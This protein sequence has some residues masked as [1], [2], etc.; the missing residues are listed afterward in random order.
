MN[1]T[2]WKAWLSEQLK[3]TWGVI[4]RPSEEGESSV[5][6]RTPACSFKVMAGCGRTGLI[7]KKGRRHEHG[8]GVSWH[9]GLFSTSRVEGGCWGWGPA[10]ARHHGREE[11]AA[12]GPGNGLLT[13]APS[14]A[15]SVGPWTKPR[16]LRVSESSSV[17]WGTNDF[18]TL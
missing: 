15:H 11:R 9:M 4:C 13:L 18:E 6:G 14:P 3:R 7:R 8:H 2:I 12:L 5:G 16:P 1:T 17:K 10:R